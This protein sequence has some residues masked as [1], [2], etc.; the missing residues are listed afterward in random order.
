MKAQLLALLKSV[1]ISWKSSAAGLAALAIAAFHVT[2]DKTMAIAMHDAGF[3]T[4]VILGILGLVVK[5][6]GVTGGSVGQPS[7]HEALNASNVS[8]SVSYP[9]VA[10]DRK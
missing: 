5:D 6:A 7:T 1:L 10:P 8:A 2:G 9:P 3:W 4:L